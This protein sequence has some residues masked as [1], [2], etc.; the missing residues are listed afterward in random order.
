M[1][2]VLAAVAAALLVV[3][4]GFTFVAA[5]GLFR[6]PDSYARLHVATKPATLGVAMTFTAAMLQ[7]PLGA[8]TTRLAV[9]VL[10]QFWTI[11]A[12]NH[13]L[14]SLQWSVS[15]GQSCLCPKRREPLFPTI[16]LKA[17][18]IVKPLTTMAHTLPI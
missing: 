6:M 2:D 15:A 5:I 10:F 18:T 13:L 9:A 1:S 11:P 17:L 4:T 12:A 14:A 16:C 8:L 3:G 7:V